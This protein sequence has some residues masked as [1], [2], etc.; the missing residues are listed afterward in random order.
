MAKECP[1]RALADEFAAHCSAGSEPTSREADA[2]MKDFEEEHPVVHP[3]PPKSPRDWCC[4]L[5]GKIV[6]RDR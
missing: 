6:Y 4:H 3:A 2:Y 1:C 5:C